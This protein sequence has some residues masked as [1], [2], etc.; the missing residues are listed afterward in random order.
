MNLIRYN[1]IVAIVVI[2][3]GGCSS[4]NLENDELRRSTPIV[5]SDD[6]DSMPTN[7]RELEFKNGQGKICRL[8]NLQGGNTL[9]IL[10]FTYSSCR[11]CVLDYLEIFNEVG[12]EYNDQV[13]V[14]VK[15]NKLRK[16]RLMDNQYKNLSFFQPIKDTMYIGSYLLIDSE[17]AMCLINKK[18]EILSFRR[19]IGKDSISSPYFIAAQ[20]YLAKN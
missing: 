6:N 18:S 10:F 15:E 12:S 7:I 1:I 20:R 5:N 11:A 3:V 17:P 13:V 8:K 2:L 4:K 19:G 9:L 14:I 16:L